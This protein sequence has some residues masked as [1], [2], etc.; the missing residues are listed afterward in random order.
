MRHWGINCID[1]QIMHFF[2]DI[3]NF[4]HTPSYHAVA[5]LSDLKNSPVFDPPFTLFS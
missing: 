5:K 2:L 3:R 1:M 4:W